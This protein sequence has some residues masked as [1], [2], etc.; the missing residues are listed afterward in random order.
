M[1]KLE[2]S[3]FRIFRQFLMAPGQMLC[4][5]GPNLSKYE[6]ALRELTERGLLVKEKFHGA[7][8]LTH[9]GFA[10]MKDAE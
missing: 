6:T 1:S 5:Y 3:V 10:A 7:Y 4:F 9:D 8:S 2:R